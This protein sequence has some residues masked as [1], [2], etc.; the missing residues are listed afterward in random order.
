MKNT[1]ITILLVVYFAFA[2]IWYGWE[3]ISETL[4]M[5]FIFSV[6]FW[7]LIIISRFICWIIKWPRRKRI[8]T[9]FPLQAVLSEPQTRFLLH[10][11]LC[12]R[13]DLED[14]LAHEWNACYAD[15]IANRLDQIKQIHQ[16]L[17]FGVM[18][19]EDISKLNRLYGY[20]ET[21]TTDVLNA[22]RT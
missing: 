5:L 13:L 4:A 15:R 7:G 18:T 6:A 22:S 1:V 2:G 3:G 14:A 9:L 19:P 10:D 20:P 21:E 11:L 17:R 8:R 12:W 16:K